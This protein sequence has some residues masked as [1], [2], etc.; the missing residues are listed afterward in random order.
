MAPVAAPAPAPSTPPTI[1]PVPFCLDTNA[2]VRAPAPAP[3]TAP[4]AVLLQPFFFSVVVVVAAV[5]PEAELFEPEEV[6]RAAARSAF[7]RLT[8][9]ITCCRAVLTALTESMAACLAI[10]ISS[11]L[12]LLLQAIDKVVIAQ[13]A[14]NRFFIVSFL[15]E[16][17]YLITYEN[18]AIFKK[19]GCLNRQP[20]Y[21]MVT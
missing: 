8:E 4:L 6:L 9:S 2:P 5:L 10:P 14:I 21:R 7:S 3:I 18:C 20:A 19:L 11:V 15:N 16:H 13:K 12:G 1:A 17:G